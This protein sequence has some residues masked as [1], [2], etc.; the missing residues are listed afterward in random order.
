MRASITSTFTG[1]SVWRIDTDP[2][3]PSRVCV[4]SH[5]TE[6]PVRIPYV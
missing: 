1:V 5:A 4:V 3:A 2:V 6:L